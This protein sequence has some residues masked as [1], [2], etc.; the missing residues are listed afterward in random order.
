[1]GGLMGGIAII[2]SALGQD[3]QRKNGINFRYRLSDLE[4]T[5]SRSVPELDNNDS[6]DSNNI[7]DIIDI[8]YNNDTNDTN[9]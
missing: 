7:N 5:W 3:L 6:N 2:E 1:M 8:N 9:N 4:L